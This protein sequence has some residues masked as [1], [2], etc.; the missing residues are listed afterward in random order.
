VDEGDTG[1]QLSIRRQCKCKEM[2]VL[3][4]TVISDVIKQ[5]FIMGNEQY[6]ARMC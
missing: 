4:V 2:Y 6:F 3:V 1:T 5:Q